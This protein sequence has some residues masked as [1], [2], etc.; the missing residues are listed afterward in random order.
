VRVRQGPAQLGDRFREVALVVAR[1]LGA[2]EARAVMFSGA[3]PGAGCTTAVVETARNLVLMYGAKVVLVEFDTREPALADRFRLDRT[4]GLPAY[5]SGERT[6]DECLQTT[7]DGFVVLP[8][9]EMMPAGRSGMISPLAR[10]LGELEARFD[11]ILLDMPPALQR[12]DVLAVGA[13]VP[14]VVIV[15]EAERTHFATLHRIRGDLA[16]EG[17][18]V[19]GGV[20]NKRRRFIPR[21][22][23]RRVNP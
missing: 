11:Y 13:L 3:G 1:A 5:A 22:I 10:L 19:L 14:Q 7:P 23:D 20:L 21:W 17:I 12:A 6:L 16:R 4:R 2:K 8:G 9:G 18:A 15:V